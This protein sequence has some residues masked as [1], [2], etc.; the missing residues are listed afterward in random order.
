MGVRKRRQTWCRE[1]E[2][3]EDRQLLSIFLTPL[4]VSATA[5]QPSTNSVA[6]LFDSNL[7]TPP[8]SF[9]AVIDWGAG[10][11]PTAGQVVGTLVPGVFL[12]NGTYTYPSSGNFTTHISVSDTA[13]E[14]ASTNGSAFVASSGTPPSSP[15]TIAGNTVVGTAGVPLPVQVV[16][17]FIDPNTADTATDFSALIQWGNGTSSI[18][19][20]T[21]NP[22]GPSNAFIV[23]GGGTKYGSAGTFTTT[24]TIV[25][26]SGAPSG[27]ANGTAVIAAASPPLVGQTIVA[28][29]GQNLAGVVVA[30]FT[31]PVTSDTAGQLSTLISWGDGQS[32]SGTANPTATAGV[33]NITGSHTYQAVGTYPI[34]VTLTTPEGA[35]FSG[36]GTANVLNPNFNGTFTGGLAP[37]PGNGPNA[38]NGFTTTNRPLFSGTAPAFSTVQLFARPANV[39]VNEPLAYAIANSSGNWTLATGPLA[40]GFYTVTAV[41]TSPGGFPSQPQPTSNN[42]SV[43]VDTQ[44]PKVVSVRYNGGNQVTVLF[45][46][47]TSGMSLASL[48]NPAN[49]TLTGPHGPFFHPA[50]ISPS[51]SVSPG[52]GQQVVLTFPS[53]RRGRS[54]LWVF[55]MNMGITD[56][57]GN[58]LPAFSQEIVLPASRQTSVHHR[59][60]RV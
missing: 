56:N 20:V 51:P 40:D 22:N 55:T 59:K 24:V 31:D 15:L 37:V 9:S 2:C 10:Q 26:T 42:G 8:G 7:T 13:G 32:S 38:V 11:A 4:N 43:V 27:V 14:T 3:L 50:A 35:T 57:A 53:I 45:S 41:V 29:A 21:P 54:S 12:I 23:T 60:A 17:S 46:D 36:S 34:T 1:L 28:S 44:A 30:K 18:G 47:A 25:G 6:T 39:D 49:Y 33:F 5:G 48:K 52:A 58:P 19:S 16:A